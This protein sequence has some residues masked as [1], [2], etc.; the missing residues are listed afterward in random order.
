MNFLTWLIGLL[1]GKLPELPSIPHR[2]DFNQIQF[3]DYQ[4][5]G[6]RYKRMIVSKLPI[7]TACLPVLHDTHSMDGLINQDTN[8]VLTWSKEDKYK[9]QVGD[10]SIW[11]DKETGVSRT[12]Q[13]V[14]TNPDG[15]F[16]SKGSNPYIAPDP[17]TITPDEI[18]YVTLAVLG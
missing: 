18:I 2:I 1:T 4:E 13:L 9:P 16:Q 11:A 15:S 3:E 5:D 17:V 6:K 14:G 12:H 8:L 7:E 10:V